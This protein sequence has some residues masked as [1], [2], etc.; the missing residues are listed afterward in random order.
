[1]KSNAPVRNELFLSGKKHLI[2]LV[3]WEADYMKYKEI[4]YK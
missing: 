3:A 2:E 1:M 4:I